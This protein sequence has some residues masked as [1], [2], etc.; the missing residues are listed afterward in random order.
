ML[1]WRLKKKQQG[2]CYCC[3]TPEWEYG[4]K[5]DM[6]RVVKG[7]NGGE[8]NEE[9]VVLV[10]KKCHRKIEGMDRGQ[11]DIVRAFF[12]GQFTGEIDPSEGTEED[13]Q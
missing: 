6:H 8:Y 4:R 1:Y 12:T 2:N 13:D 9:N 10:C 3:Q 5:F 11:I 7:L